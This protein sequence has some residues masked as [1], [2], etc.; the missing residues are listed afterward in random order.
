MQLS[1]NIIND[2]PHTVPHQPGKKKPGYSVLFSTGNYLLVGVAILGLAFR[3]SNLLAL[4]IFADEMVHIQGGLAAQSG[5]L[6]TEGLFSLIWTSRVIHG[7]LLGIIYFLFDNS[8]LLL[9][10][11]LFS[12][13]CGLLTILICYKIGTQLYSSRAGLLA[14]T[15]WAITPFI[16]WHERLILVDPLLATCTSLVFYFSLAL[17]R[18]GKGRKSSYYGLLLGLSLAAAFLTKFS[19][20]LIVPVPVLAVLFLAPRS[21]WKFFIPRYF[22]A[23]YIAGLLVLPVLFL[24][25]DNLGSYQREKQI[26]LPTF[27]LIGEHLG[28]IFA[29][30]YTYL[31]LPLFALLIV[32]I[33]GVFVNRQATG[34]FLLLTAFIP[35]VF[36][37]IF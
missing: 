37:G 32:S 24:N 12:G 21:R 34:K 20:A 27:A 33:G 30:F 14:A 3:W 16:L 29:W 17:T 4:P 9:I 26:T 13:F 7:W 11:R 19:A 31:T 1:E 36:Q 23:Y 22:L 35:L 10:G 8:N 25:R 2:A 18:L 6:N 28:N 15:F 5:K